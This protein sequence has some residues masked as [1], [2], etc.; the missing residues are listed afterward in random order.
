MNNRHVLDD[1]SAYLDGE[2]TEPARVVRHLQTCAPCAKRYQELRVLSGQ[3]RAL[4]PPAVS[5]E[6]AA[7]VTNTSR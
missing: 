4:K 7:R 1:L 3:V 2:C 6:F 5:P